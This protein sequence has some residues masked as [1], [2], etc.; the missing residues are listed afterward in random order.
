MDGLLA[1]DKPAGP[2][3][4]D[5]VARVRRATGWKRV[6]HT[7]TLDPL[8]TGVL[9]LVVGRA[10]RLAQFLP[11]E[12]EYEAEITLGWATDTYDSLGQ[13]TG[14][15]TPSACA[16][17]PQL[18]EV[19]PRFVGTYDQTPP[20]F[21]AKKIDGV[22]AYALAR[23]G[24]GVVPKAVPVTVHEITEIEA[25]GNLLRLRIRCSGGFYVRSFAHDLGLALG[26]GAHLS[27]LRRT[28]VGDVTVADAV[29][30]A[31]VE[32]DPAVAA[33]RLTPIARLLEHLPRV[34][35][36]ADAATRVRHGNDLRPGEWDAPPAPPQAG[37]SLATSR[38]VRVFDEA[39][40]LIAIGK[41]REDSGILR[42]AVVV[43]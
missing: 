5:V 21:S 11:G 24:N 9:A 2:T 42:P 3:S 13:P 28:A 41:R 7:G 10:T 12:K 34:V 36:R 19:L 6:G 17:R 37:W 30:L 31:S 38:H 22:R 25:H 40:A 35:V 1:I 18:D 4:H 32:E 39:G 27:A 43:G 23:R 16:T 8:A 29:S 33:A 15:Q 26:V 20:P 14:L